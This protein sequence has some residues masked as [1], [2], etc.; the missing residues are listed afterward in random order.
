[1]QQISQI[2]ENEAETEPEV[3]YSRLIQLALKVAFA[4]SE[5]DPAAA[6][7]LGEARPTVPPSDFL[8]AIAAAAERMR[9]R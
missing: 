5:R 4:A 1:M 9:I 6:G 2:L 3:S 8:A 7:L